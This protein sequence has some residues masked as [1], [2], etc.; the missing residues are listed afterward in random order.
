MYIYEK[1]RY[2]L[3][4]NKEPFS[5]VARLMQKTIYCIYLSEGLTPI[6][7]EYGKLQFLWTIVCCQKL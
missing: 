6:L 3:L 2:T 7:S 1:R 4:M 5:H